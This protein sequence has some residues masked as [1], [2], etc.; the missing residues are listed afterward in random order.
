M[1]IMRFNT[2]CWFTLLVLLFALEMH[3][4]KKKKKLE[5]DQTSQLVI[6][7]A[8]FSVRPNPKSGKKSCIS[9][10]KKFWPKEDID[11]QNSMPT[12]GITVK[13]V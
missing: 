10:I 3:V 1:K 6:F 7:R 9:Q 4:F 5:N 13:P 2:D 11:V 12:K 8:F